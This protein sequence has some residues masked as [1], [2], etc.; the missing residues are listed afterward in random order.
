MDKFSN[1]FSILL[2]L[3][4]ILA[5]ILY[6][7]L[8]KQRINQAVRY[9]SALIGL[10]FILSLSTLITSGGSTET[11]IFLFSFNSAAL[12]LC[13]LVLFISFII[14]R[15]SIRYM[16]GDRCYSLYFFRLSAISFST[17]MMALADNLILFWIA[18][19]TSNMLLIQLMIHK[20]KWQAA[21][22]SGMLALKT[23]APASLFLLMAFGILY[24][25]HHTLSIQNITVYA[26]AYA[27]PPVIQSL[28]LALILLCSM[29][30]SAIWPFHRWLLSSLN[31][32]TPVSAL[33]HA[34]LINGG[35]FLII[36]FAPLFMMEQY[37]LSILFLLGAFTALSG[38]LWKLL[39][40]NIK[41]MLA[42]SSMAQM[43]FMMMQCA[44]GLFPAAMAHLCWHGLFKSYL[45]L[46]TGSVLRQKKYSTPAP[47]QSMMHLV[48]ACTG[49]VIG[50]TGFALVTKKPILSLHAS[51]F[52]LGFAFI[53][54]TQ[55]TLS[56][57]EEKKRIGQLVLLFALVFLCGGFYGG[58]I[59][60]LESLLP[61][62]AGF[63]KNQLGILQG[64]TLILFFSFWLAFRFGLFEQMKKTRF[65]DYLYM[66][67]LNASTA[68]P[69]TFSTHRSTYYY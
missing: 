44:L 50:M 4:P 12:L 5:M 61:N 20:S 13:T 43:G 48:L 30:Q 10:S 39:Q 19:S 63:S 21:Y 58:S 16:F 35:G 33:M 7:A 51:S 22:H 55:L 26:H 34:G 49:G 24:Y 42:C 60:L 15:F 64:F 68:H 66:Q 29:A 38:S 65:W 69:K 9:G 46:S 52:L 28:A 40:S 47:K 67:M 45:F 62:L 25:L 1:I 14:H 23:L 37:L 6:I 27:K 41:S 53:T 17:L 8:G 3:P 57:I 59:Y 31:S 2:I 36:K 56:L 18:W 32:P 54:G 11:Q